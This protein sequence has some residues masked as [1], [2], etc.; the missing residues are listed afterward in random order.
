MPLFKKR[1][2]RAGVQIAVLAVILLLFLALFRFT[3]FHSFDAVTSYASAGARRASSLSA[4]DILI[5]ADNDGIA[6]LGDLCIGDRY[7]KLPIYPKHPGQ[8][9]IELRDPAD[10]SGSL[11]DYKVITISRFGTV[12][13]SSTGNFSGDT[14][15]VI[16]SALFWILV[17]AILLW[18]FFQ[19][20]GPAF[21]N[22]STI[23]FAGFSLFSVVSAVVLAVNAVLHIMNPAVHT[24]YQ[25]FSALDS[26]CVSFLYFT[27]PLI[28]VFSAAMVISNIELL[29]HERFRIQNVLGIIT[30]FLLLAGDVGI[31]IYSS[32]YFSGSLRELR[33]RNTA[34]NVLAS[35][36][37]YFECM[38]FG[39]VICGFSAAKHLP[40][41][42]RDF[43][44]IL[45]C[46]FRRDGSL[47]PLLKGRADCAIR[48]WKAQKEDTGKEAVFIPS[49]G[50]GDDETMP[51]AEAISRYLL[52]Q[53]IPQELIIPEDRSRNT[54]Q[55]M[56]YSKK[57]IDG[58][59]PD[60]KVAYATT[61]YHVFRSGLWANLAGLPSEGISGKT[62]WWFW[63]NA[64]MREIVGL[65][66]NRLRQEIILLIVAVIY[67]FLLSMLL[68]IA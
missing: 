34:E 35:I 60:A 38:L 9:A 51:E 31:L 66:R 7:I 6:G 56:E 65:L 3:G 8:F 21:Y 26:T 5:I 19:A 58:I 57:I 2:T 16:I 50:Q 15:I 22:Y 13:D 43:I 14:A 63:P 32:S 61:N 33:I 62:K 20:K 39:A 54:Y 68:P 64:F 11:I 25:I 55:N 23:F 17:S 41:H 30:A 37:V 24:M 40:A 45:G 52:S 44:L 4:E 59:N 12:S 47:T 27:S 53:D 46:R 29:K 10:E 1:S 18:H 49:G 48:F 28:L 42:D 36:Y 67:F